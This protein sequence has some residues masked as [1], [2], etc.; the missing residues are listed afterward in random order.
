MGSGLDEMNRTMLVKIKPL[1]D[2]RIEAVEGEFDLMRWCRDVIT[3]ASSEAV[4]GA[5][6]PFRDEQTTEDFW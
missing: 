2:E 6:N 5:K 3:T 4:W 1:I